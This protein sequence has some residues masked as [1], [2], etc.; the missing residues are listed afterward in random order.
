MTATRARTARGGTRPVRLSPEDV[1]RLGLIG[2]RVRTVRA[3]LSALGIS[4]G[5]ATMIMVTRIPSSSQ[6]ALLRQLTALGTNLLQAQ[7]RQDGGSAVSL[8]RNADMM[9]RR[10]GPVTHAAAVANAHR[11]IQRTD[12]SDPDDSIGINVLAARDNLLS[13]VNGSVYSG[14]FFTTATDRYPTVVLDYQAASVLGF[15]KLVPGEPAPQVVIDHRWFTV[16]GILNPM[17]LTRDLEQSD[18]VGWPAATRYLHFDGHPTVI[19]VKAREDAIDDVRGVLPATLDPQVPDLVQVSRPSDALAAKRASE[20]SFSGLFLGLAG[21]ALLV[22]GPP[23]TANQLRRDWRQR[24]TPPPR[25][26]LQ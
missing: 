18:L 20:H 9:A 5:I 25:P 8:P 16:I 23:R 4:I 21:V 12:R 14:R 19:Y 22:G 10:I 7:P 15:K 3:V 1:L 2:V 26:Q 13:T 11:S 24:S 6:Q 17:P